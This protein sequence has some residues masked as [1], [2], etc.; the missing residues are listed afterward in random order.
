TPRDSRPLADAGRTR[1]SGG[2]TQAH[3]T[4]SGGIMQTVGLLVTLTAKAGREDDVAA[5]LANARSLAEQEEQTIVWYALRL[6]QQRFA[7]FDAFASAT[8]RD[9][10][11]RGPIAAA[12]MRH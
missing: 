3:L 6:D 9:A 2:C 7:I 8:G 4:P 1:R 10:H 12:L 5:F 11:L